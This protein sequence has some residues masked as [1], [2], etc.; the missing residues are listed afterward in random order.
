VGRKFDQIKLND[1]TSEKLHYVVTPP[2]PASIQ[3]PASMCSNHDEMSSHRGPEDTWSQQTMAS[4]ST[5]NDLGRPPPQRGHS[6][7]TVKRR[8]S[9]VESLRNLFFSKGQPQTDAR[10][11]FLLKKR[12]RSEEKETVSVQHCIVYIESII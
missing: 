4:T 1:P 2:S 3:R 8:V 6:E 12:T 11:R 9:R 10:R 5:Q 7:V